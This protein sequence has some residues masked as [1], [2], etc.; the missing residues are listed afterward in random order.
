[1][2]VVNNRDFPYTVGRTPNTSFPLKKL[3]T[4]LYCSSFSCIYP[5]SF[6][7]FVIASS[8]LFTMRFSSYCNTSLPLLQ[9][10]CSYCGFTRS[11]S[12]TLCIRHKCKRKPRKAGN[13][14]M[15]FSCQPDRCSAYANDL[16][17]RM[18]WQREAL[19]YSYDKIASNLCVWTSPTVW[20]TIQ[21]FL[22][23][24]NVTKRPYPK[25]RA[26]RILTKPA[27]LLILHLVLETPGIYLNEI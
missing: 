8:M 22:T 23:T 4:I 15:A 25:E 2:P 9:N 19:R 1:M 20:R 24:G 16:H 10:V 11:C 6:T 13:L 12:K 21:L 14:K 18:V 17:W 3:F 5:S 7:E 26:H 27:Q